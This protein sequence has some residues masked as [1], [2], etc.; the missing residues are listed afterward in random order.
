MPQRVQN[1]S[2]LLSRWLPLLYLAEEASGRDS[3]ACGYSSECSCPRGKKGWSW[4][5][6]LK[7]LG[8]AAQGD[9]ATRASWSSN[10]PMLQGRGDKCSPLLECGSSAWGCSND[11]KMIPALLLCPPHKT[12][13]TWTAGPVV[14][15]MKAQEGPAALVEYIW[16]MQSHLRSFT[17]S[18]KMDRDTINLRCEGDPFLLLLHT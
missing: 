6:Q 18:Q 1:R 16:L 4:L 9:E 7:M 12:P 17:V 3:Q 8:P 15:L 10:G 14:V 13:E 5:H 2:D 11:E